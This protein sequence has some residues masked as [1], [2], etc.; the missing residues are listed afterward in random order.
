[1]SHH[2]QWNTPQCGKSNLIVPR[3]QP[4]ENSVG[5]GVPAGQANDAQEDRCGSAD[6]LI[7]GLVDRLPK[8]NSTWSADDRARWLRTAIRVFDLVYKASDCEP[9]DIDIVFTKRDGSDQPVTW[10]AAPE[11]KDKPICH[12]DALSGNQPSNSNAI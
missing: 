8:L 12:F 11:A 6:L 5:S 10:L 3:S 7:Q 1:M 9:R 2:Q 4:I